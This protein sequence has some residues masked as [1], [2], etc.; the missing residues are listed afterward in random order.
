MAPAPT[1]PASTEPKL[2]PVVL[3]KYKD[4]A[5]LVDKAIRHVLTLTKEGAKVLEICKEGDK[6]IEEE[7]DKVYNKKGVKV[8]KGLAFPTT[9][10]VNGVLANFSPLPSDPNFAGLELKKDDLVKVQIGAHIDGYASFAGETIVVGDEVKE[11][12]VRADLITAAFQASEIALRTVKPG[13][14]N[15]EVTQGIASVLSEYKEKKVKGVELTANSASFGWRMEKDDIQAKKTITPFPTS[16]QR[17]DSDNNHT[18]EEGEV[19]SLTVAVTNATE[20]KVRNI[21]GN[22]QGISVADHDMLRLGQRDI[23]RPNVALLPSA[24]HL[25]AQDEGFARDIL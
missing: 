18:L 6:K 24:Y 4:A 12:D 13:A 16:E 5:K 10:S 3:D 17:R 8:A 21:S 19:Y 11:G 22:I 23:L 2:S 25:P 15:W 7:A 9:L 1:T 14:K 20:A